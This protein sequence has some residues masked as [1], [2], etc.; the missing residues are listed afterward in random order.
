MHNFLAI[1]L[2]SFYL[3]IFSIEKTLDIV[4]EKSLETESFRST[5]KNVYQFIEGSWCTKE[6]AKL[7]M[8]LILLEKPS[9]CVEIGT[10]LGHSAIP[11][12]QVLK[13]LNIGKMYLIDSW[14][15]NDAVKGLDPE[16]IHTKWWASIDF[17]NIKHAFLKNIQSMNLT[18]YCTVIAAPSDQAISAIPEIDFLHIDG[19][20]SEEGAFLDTQL[21]LPKVKTN[22]YILISNLFFQIN[23]S[24]TKMK[25]LFPIFEECEI[26]AEIENGNSIL[27]KKK[28]TN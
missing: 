7:L 22:G 14:T 24:A 15:N 9:I 3:P 8:S 26:I 16:N 10:F 27:F 1:F 18:S 4:Y 21:Y 13:H 20:F 2:L 17:K 5:V 6:K 28:G 25:S 11:V 23:H 12:L 19:N